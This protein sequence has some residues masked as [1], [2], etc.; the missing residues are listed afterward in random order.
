M[1][2]LAR[3]PAGAQ[4]ELP[5]G[6]AEGAKVTAKAARKAGAQ[7]RQAAADKD[8]AKERRMKAIRA[9]AIAEVLAASAAIAPFEPH[10][11]EEPQSP[12]AQATGVGEVPPTV[13][14]DPEDQMELSTAQGE[15][16]GGAVKKQR[17][18]RSA[19]T[20][21]YAEGEEEDLWAEGEAGVEGAKAGGGAAKNN[22]PRR[23]ANAKEEEVPADSTEG[24]A[25]V[26]AA[27]N[28]KPRRS[29]N[30]KEA[31]GGVSALRISRPDSSTLA[32]IR[33]A[34]VAEVLAAR[35]GSAEPSGKESS[36]GPAALPHAGKD[37]K[38][39]PSRKTEDKLE[40]PR[41]SADGSKSAAATK[42]ADDSKQSDATAKPAGARKS[43]G[44][45]KQ[46][47]APAKKPAAVTAEDAAAAR[48]K[49]KPFKVGG[50]NKGLLFVPTVA[51]ELPQVAAPSPAPHGPAPPFD[52][53][54]PH[55]LA[56]NAT[57]ALTANSPAVAP[58]Q[59]KR[60][61]FNPKKGRKNSG[62]CDF[63]AMDTAPDAPPEAAPQSDA[64]LEDGVEMA[65]QA[66]RDR[67][68]ALGLA[69]VSTEAPMAAPLGRRE[70]ADA[71][72]LRAPLV[73]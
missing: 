25:G 29:A 34:A 47:E 27:K 61:L 59:S 17:P 39:Q 3:V 48:P 45:R 54:S 2:A 18:R 15:D 30:A 62:L 14:V 1:G 40:K 65:R 19:Y 35:A 24:E 49:P 33:A 67:R 43:A 66:R 51:S 57:A 46:A 44:A 52:V 73:A 55:R 23:S 10:V 6:A 58:S 13:K 9:E 36:Q 56:P 28:N 4:A 69:R 22:K 21:G 53:L 26:G 63:N 72:P 37:S 71:I 64:S 11:S 42:S 16:A 68:T 38:P 70:A 41:K 31:E 7:Q 5:A 32:T 50:F 20:G 12:L 60:S 8:E